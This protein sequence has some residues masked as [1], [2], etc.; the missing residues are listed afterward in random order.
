MGCSGSQGATNYLASPDVET[1]CMF[2]SKL[3]PATGG[4]SKVKMIF[5]LEQVPSAQVTSR[6]PFD[7]ERQAEAFCGTFLSDIEQDVACALNIPSVLV[8][9]DKTTSC[10]WTSSTGQAIVVNLNLHLLDA[11]TLPGLLSPNAL[12][13]AL[14]AQHKDHNSKLWK[15]YLTKTLDK[16]TLLVATEAQNTTTTTTTTTTKTTTTT[17]SKAKAKLDVSAS[18][19]TKA[20]A[21]KAPATGTKDTS[22][23]TFSG[24]LTFKAKDA[25]EAEAFVNNAA[26]KGVMADAI[27]AAT[28]MVTKDMVKVTSLTVGSGRR[29]SDI[30]RRLAGH[31]IICKY[32][33]TFPEGFAG[34]PTLTKDSLDTTVLATKIKEKAAAAGL[35]VT[36]SELSVQ[37]IVATSPGA[38]TGLEQTASSAIGLVHSIGIM[39][40]T[41]MSQML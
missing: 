7:T 30:G 5:K 34:T 16:D 23:K 6:P 25:K 2:D 4:A 3:A 15:G 10:G 13:E 8:K 31:T 33:V 28:K 22:P 14:V 26:S 37:Q 17:T 19:T 29:L 36:V 21:T 40:V 11:G 39:T 1:C 18:T 12:A 35:T 9:A 41:M 20:P 38:T 24:G 32:T 27:A